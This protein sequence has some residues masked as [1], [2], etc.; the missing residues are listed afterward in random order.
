MPHPAYAYVVGAHAALATAALVVGGV[1]L[2][3]TKGG[4]THR[5]AGRGYSRAIGGVVATGALATAV[6]RPTLYL[7]TLLLLTAYPT[8]SGVRV[9][10][11][12][13]P[14][15]DPAQ[16]ARQ[17][18]WVAAAAT[19]AASLLLLA[20]N[21]RGLGGRHAGAIWGTA[22]FLTAFAVYDLWRFTRPAAR[23][24]GPTLWL[25]E[26]IGKLTGAYF[27]AVSAFSG[28]VATA[29]PDPW[30]VLVPNLTGVVVM[31]I[32]LA[33]LRRGS[34]GHVARRAGAEAAAFV[35]PAAPA[36]RVA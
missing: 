31:V 30:R 4:L 12:K 14:D 32:F 18:D 13:R 19:L 34:F 10:G 26:H 7:T 22:P 6:G 9:L 15:V 16:R 24:M 3:S 25:R 36:G 23:P 1:A 21:A 27:G 2:A 17:A 33:R 20:A 35:A 5:R 11:R 8:W 29:V 28:N